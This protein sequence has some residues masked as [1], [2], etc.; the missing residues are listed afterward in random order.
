MINKSGL[1]F[2]VI[3]TEKYRT[4]VWPNGFEVTINEPTHLNISESGG[5]RLLD[6]DGK[7]HYIPTGWVHIYW[8]VFEGKPNFV[9]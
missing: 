8:E 3:N 7:S 4:Y 1:E 6:N 5:H 9:K 2:I